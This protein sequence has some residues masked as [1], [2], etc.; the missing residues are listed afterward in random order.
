[1]SARVDG[2][3]FRV[4]LCYV[5]LAKRLSISSISRGAGG[6]RLELGQVEAVVGAV[7]PA[8]GL[9]DA[10]LLLVLL[11]DRV[12]HLIDALSHTA[13]KHVLYCM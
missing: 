9:V 11:G 5:Y 1:M 10:L 4:F 3:S 2:V 13:M 6:E 12:A 8:H 7:C